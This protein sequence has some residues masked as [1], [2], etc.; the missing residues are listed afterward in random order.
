MFSEELEDER[1]FADSGRPLD[2]QDLWLSR[3]RAAKTAAN[4]FN[5]D[6]P[7]TKTRAG[8]ES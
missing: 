6:S 3:L 4:V 7:P 8:H 2:E 1:G 5:S